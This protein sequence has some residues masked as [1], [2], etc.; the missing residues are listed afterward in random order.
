[1]FVQG[2][3]ADERTIPVGRSFNNRGMRNDQHDA[4]SAELMI[5]IG[6]PRP[7]DAPPAASGAS[8][9]AGASAP[10]VAA[11]SA[12][13]ALEVEQRAAAE[14]LAAAGAPELAKA[15][16]TTQQAAADAGLPHSTSEA[17]GASPL[18]AAAKQALKVE[19]PDRA[20]GFAAGGAPQPAVAASSA[21]QATA[22]GGPQQAKAA[23]PTG[24]AAA[25][26]AF[27]GIAYKASGAPSL[28][29]AAKQALE[30]EQPAEAERPAAGGAPQL[31]K[32]PSAAEQ[33]AAGDA[34][35]PAAAKEQALEP[36]QPA[37]DQRP[38]AG[39][40]PQ[41]AVAAS[42]AEQA[43]AGGALQPA[44]PPAEAAAESLSQDWYSDVGEATELHER[45]R[46][47]EEADDI[48]PEVQMELARI[49]FQKKKP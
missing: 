42:A 30:I 12:E 41:P 11:A 37:G 16:S 44:T 36:E 24:Q 28:P 40:A 29:A 8:Q 19:E 22:G 26:D 13:Q 6:R 2:A 5:P 49:L 4:V 20:E 3:F 38:A 43:A 46:E 7:E 34:P 18:P 1:M 31:A 9:P 17:R 39:G 21:E 27:P 10:A 45:L 32:A 15:V 48:K 47:V 35:Q 33:A 25:N 14:R 23:S